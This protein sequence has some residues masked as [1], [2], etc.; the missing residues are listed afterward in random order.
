MQQT[1]YSGLLF[2]ADT[3]FRFLFTF[4]S[5]SGL[6]VADTP[7]NRPYKILLVRNNYTIYFRQCFTVSLK[8][9][10][11]FVNLFHSQFNGVF[12]SIKIFRFISSPHSHLWLTRF[13]V[14]KMSKAQQGQR[15]K[16]GCNYE[17]FCCA[18]PTMSS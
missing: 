3:I 6:S 1:L 10:S 11:I 17:D 7:D 14:T 16:H 15:Q 9:S 18:W 4:S 2:I 12:R 8:F 13:L 5:R